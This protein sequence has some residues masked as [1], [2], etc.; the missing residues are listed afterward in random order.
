MVWFGIYTLLLG[1]ALYG[2]G[3][4]YAQYQAHRVRKLLAESARVQI[5]DSEDSA[6]ELVRRYSG[7]SWTPDVLGP[8]ENWIDKDEYE[9]QKS[10]LSDNK[11][12]IA[13]S[14]L[15]TIFRPD[16]RKYAVI[17]TIQ[18][19][20]PSDFRK[21]LGMRLW[22]TTV[23]LSIQNGHV[24]SISATTQLEGRNGWLEQRWSLAKDMPRRDM[25]ARTYLIG[26]AFLTTGDGGGTAIENF[27]TPRASAE[28][29]QAARNFNSECLT[30]RRA[31]EGLCELA[32]DTLNYLTQHP[33]LAWNIIPPKC[34]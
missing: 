32:P 5:G 31:C 13:L 16:G 33:D 4:A 30:R 11:Y 9:Y 23:E 25:P 14:T 24:Q 12:E 3:L 19:A 22:I 10:R 17:G 34:R 7:F 1:I 27:F 28:E 2:V 8:K 18:R 26:A 15:G 29:K 20:M 21:I 6:F